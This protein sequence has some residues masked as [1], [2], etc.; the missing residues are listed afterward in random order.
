MHISDFHFIYCNIYFIN[1]GTLGQLREN[2]LQDWD[3]S[4]AFWFYYKWKFPRC[5]KSCST[6]YDPRYC[7]QPGSFVHG[8]SQAR[9]LKWVIIS[10][11]R[12]SS[13]S[14]YWTGIS[15]LADGFFRLYTFKNTCP[16]LQ[17]H[18]KQNLTYNLQDKVIPVLHAINCSFCLLHISIT[19]IAV[20]L[21]QCILVITP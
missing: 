1:F 3:Y 17:W 6:L 19:G 8:I 16:W 9:I 7:R 20:Y 14:R 4:S 11:S 2:H 15:C 12:E 5:L 10:F 21:D 18:F 13:W